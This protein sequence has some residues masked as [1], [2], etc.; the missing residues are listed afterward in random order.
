MTRTYPAPAANSPLPAPLRWRRPALA[1][2]RSARLKLTA[3]LQ[4]LVSSGFGDSP[5]SSS[6]SLKTGSE[7]TYFSDAQFP[8]SRS[9]QRSLQKGNSAFVAESTKVLQIGHRRCMENQVYPKTRKAAPVE[10]RVKVSAGGIECAVEDLCPAG[11]GRIS[12]T[13]PIRSYASVLV[14]S[15]CAASPTAAVSPPGN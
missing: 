2:Y 6:L 1:S 10:I 3:W 14:I 11:C 12:T 13:R 15:T 4:C 8:R 7:T 9:R 5:N